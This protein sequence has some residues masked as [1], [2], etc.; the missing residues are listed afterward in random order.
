MN[1]DVFA[2]RIAR[3]TYGHSHCDEY[4]SSDPRHVKARIDVKDTSSGKKKY[5]EDLFN[6]L[7]KVGSKLPSGHKVQSTGWRTV[8]KKQERITMRIFATPLGDIDFCTSARQ[9]GSVEVSCTHDQS[10]ALSLE[11]GAT[12]ILASAWNETTGQAAEAKLRYD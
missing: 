10:V 4:D 11:F 3:F 12:E 7:V 6:N 1:Q 2:S 8:Y 9:I 5:A